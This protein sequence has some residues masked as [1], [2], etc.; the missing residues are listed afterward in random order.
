MKRWR[1][2]LPALLL[3]MIVVV[4][5]AAAAT[6]VP[7]LAGEYFRNL[8]T[9]NGVVDCAAGAFSATYSGTATGSYAG[10]F[11]ETVRGAFANQDLTSFT[12]AFAISSGTTTV[13]GS[14]TITEKLAFFGGCHNGTFFFT[15]DTAALVS[16]TYNATIQS[17]TGNYH[18][19]GTARLYL[20]GGN[21]GTTPAGLLDAVFTANRTQPVLLTPTGKDQCED[22]GYQNFG[23]LFKG[24]NECVSSVEVGR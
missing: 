19:E 5:P 11:T 17:V 22:G 3:A 4:T 8:S 13:K 12:A 2:A 20:S 14:K 7:T 6:P 1:Y 24:Q 16:V 23:A 21:A 9:T 15:G 18:D 10:T